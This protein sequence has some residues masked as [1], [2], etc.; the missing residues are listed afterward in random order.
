[1]WRIGSIKSFLCVG[2]ILAVSS[3]LVAQDGSLLRDYLQSSSSMVRVFET[4][5]P[6][7]GK[8][9]KPKI[10][11]IRFQADVPHKGGRLVTLSRSDS[12]EPEYYYVCS[13]KVMDQSAGYTL[14]KSPIQ[15]NDE[16]QDVDPKSN[17]EI[18]RV[19]VVDVGATMMVGKKRHADCVVLLV[20]LKRFERIEVKTFARGVGLVDV[21]LYASMDDYKNG[22][23]LCEEKLK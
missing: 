16:W 12:D 7:S 6:G 10:I 3:M 13:D 14:L 9:R 4:N 11:K 17:R 8:G 1:M 20:E 22:K 5:C 2:L 19:K 23:I 15:K 21:K 18:A